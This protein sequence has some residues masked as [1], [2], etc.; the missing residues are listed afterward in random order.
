VVSRHLV[1][2]RIR[3][4]VPTTAE[5][6]IQLDHRHQALPLD[7]RETQPCAQQLPL[8]VEQAPGSARKGFAI[9]FT[10]KGPGWLSA[11]R[12]C[13][14]CQ[15]SL[16]AVIS[17]CVP[18]E[19]TV[20]LPRSGTPEL[21]LLWYLGSIPSGHDAGVAEIDLHVGRTAFAG[22]IPKG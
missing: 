7:L 22:A 19:C 5:R 6:A 1:L 2:T 20:S 4:P 9:E 14:S 13:V 12:D 15:S 17:V 8:R 10:G 3:Y 21:P 11:A 16:G 18:R